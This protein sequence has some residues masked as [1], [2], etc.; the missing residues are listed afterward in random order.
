MF[1]LSYF[2][3]LAGRLRGEPI[4]LAIGTKS[5]RGK[6]RTGTGPLEAKPCLPAPIS[7]ATFAALSPS[8]SPALMHDVDPAVILDAAA[9]LTHSLRPDSRV[10]AAQT[11][12]C[13]VTS[14]LLSDSAPFASLTDLER[15]S[16][17]QFILGKNYPNPYINETTV[18]FTLLNAADVQLTIYDSLS[19]K[20]ASV[21]RRGMGAGDHQITLNFRGLELPEGEQIYQLQVSNRHG[22][23][24][25]RRTMQTG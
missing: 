5:G 16:G 1:R 19:R 20:V 11:N 6:G 8:P 10:A 25:Q 13:A 14:G 15:E 3:H 21:V 7:V 18:P 2:A 9:V 22:V 24:R 12:G 23:Y 4:V 17:G